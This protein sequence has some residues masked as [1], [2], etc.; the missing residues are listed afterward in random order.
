MII[1][2]KCYYVSWQLKAIFVVN[3]KEKC[4][5]WFLLKIK[6]YFELFFNF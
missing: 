4:D 6:N 2:Q 5:W 1:T 3:S